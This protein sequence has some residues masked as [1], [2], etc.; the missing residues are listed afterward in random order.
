MQVVRY[1]ALIT[2]VFYGIAHKRTLQKAKDEEKQHHA[3]HEREML[4]K[5]A[6]EA[7]KRQ[8]ASAKDERKCFPVVLRSIR[9]V[10]SVNCCR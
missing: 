1:S 8:Q 6:K 4:I 5:Q 7:W 3:V 9:A 2:G 10:R